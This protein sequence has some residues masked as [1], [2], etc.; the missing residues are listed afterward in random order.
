MAIY[1]RFL[2]KNST[3]RADGTASF[4]HNTLLSLRD[5]IGA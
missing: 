5:E 2:N 4:V 1:S 3:R